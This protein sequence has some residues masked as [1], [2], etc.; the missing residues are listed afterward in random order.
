MA[1][2]DQG[3]LG[4]RREDRDDGLVVGDLPLLRADGVEDDDAVAVEHEDRWSLP[5]TER[6]ADDVVRIEHRVV[7]VGD[8]RKRHRMLLGEPFDRRNRFGRDGD[9]R[10]AGGNE[11]FVVVTQLREVP[12]AERSGE[13]TQEHDDDRPGGEQVVEGDRMTLT[14]GEREP[15]G[16]LAN[17]RAGA[18][19]RHPVDCTAGKDCPTLGVHW[20]GTTSTRG[21]VASISMFE[22]GEASRR[23]RIVV[24]E[25]EP[26]IPANDN[27]ALAA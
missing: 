25:P 12:A 5:E 6:A 14:V 4:Q 13:T 19:N 15:R 11:L 22:M 10:R 17:R 1:K 20:F 2:R 21:C 16:R 24:K 18:V 8:D 9:H 23:L 27:L 26:Y 3:E 7:G